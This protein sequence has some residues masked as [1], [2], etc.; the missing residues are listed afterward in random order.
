MHNSLR[1]CLLGMTLISGIA[2]VSGNEDSSV[3]KTV[4]NSNAAILNRLGLVPLE[5]P[6]GHHKKRLA[7]PEP[8]AFGAQSRI[9][10]PYSRRHGH[11]DSHVY[12]VKL[13][14][15]PPYYTFTKPHKSVKD[16]NKIQKNLASS[17]GFHSNGK[18]GKIYHW[19]LPLMMKIAEKKRYQSQMKMDQFKKKMQLENEKQ[20][21]D[22]EIIKINSNDINAIQ[23][24]SNVKTNINDID[25]K[26]NFNN[27]K[28][29]H[30]TDNRLMYGSKPSISLQKHSR[31]ND[32]RL[33]YPISL[34]VGSKKIKEAE[35]Y[36]T[37][38]ST[39]KMFRLADSATYRV[40]VNA[41]DRFLAWNN[42]SNELHGSRNTP[43]EQK[44]KKH[45]K[46]AAMS[47]YAP[48]SPKSGSTS[49]H[50]NFPGNGK[51]KAFYVMEKS[52]KPIYY[53]QLLP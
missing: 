45:R 10:Q 11:R 42:L 9:H 32:K 21:T 37:K 31:N 33:S 47:Y 24:I 29:F 13:P 25:R 48:L 52:R 46:K 28:Y 20:K 43:D 7:G 40:G 15:S 17:V 1:L 51:P 30:S 36:K 6:D 14:A 26:Q 50:K 38:N 8:P 53:H 35:G 34:E 41:N 16:D 19:N 3:F 2:V 12:I 39:N 4:R 44:P 5:I 27:G 49:I 23:A 22:S 18:P